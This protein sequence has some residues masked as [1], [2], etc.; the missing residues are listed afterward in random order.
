MVTRSGKQLHGFQ[1]EVS[2]ALRFRLQRELKPGAFKVLDHIMTAANHSNGLAAAYIPG[3]PLPRATVRGEFISSAPKIADATN[4][5]ER[6]VRKHLKKTLATLPWLTLRIEPGYAGGAPDATGG[7][8][9]KV[10]W[11]EANEWAEGRQ[12]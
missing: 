5:S 11:K 9:A 6:T 3:E 8:Y 12:C 1:A 2:R 4:M 10:D 7:I